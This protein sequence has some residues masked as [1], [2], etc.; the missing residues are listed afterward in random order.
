MGRLTEEQRK[1]RVIKETFPGILQDTLLGHACFADLPKFL[2]IFDRMERHGMKEPP[3]L[4]AFKSIGNYDFAGE[5]RKVETGALVMRDRLDF[6]KVPCTRTS[7]S[8]ACKVSW[9]SR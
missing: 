8:R 9:T 6:S 5:A 3:M 1:E 4:Q 2:P 7:S